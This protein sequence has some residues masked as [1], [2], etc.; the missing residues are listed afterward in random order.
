MKFWQ[1][2]VFLFALIALLM[3]LDMSGLA[4]GVPSWIISV[5]I[6]VAIGGFM[7]MGKRRPK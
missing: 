3:A 1:S 2:A 5:A 7:V 4:S 6:I